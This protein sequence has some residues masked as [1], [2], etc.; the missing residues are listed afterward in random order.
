MRPGRDPR[1]ADDPASAGGQAPAG[2]RQRQ[3]KLGGQRGQ[4]PAR[5]RLA[6]A[7]L[8]V[9]P[10]TPDAAIAQSPASKCGARPALPPC[11]PEILLCVKCDKWLA[12]SSQA[13]MDCASRR[14]RAVRRTS[15]RCRT[16][17]SKGSIRGRDPVR[18]HRNCIRGGRPIAR[19]VRSIAPREPNHLTVASELAG[20]G[21]RSRN[22]LVASAMVVAGL[23]GAA[24][25]RLATDAPCY[26][27][28]QR[29]RA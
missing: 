25:G 19:G 6:I 23:I 28:V 18:A 21:P 3:V 10:A 2:R 24:R 29:H 15:S 16:L 8:G 4:R 5:R 11:Y 13:W 7:A 14:S 27:G 9:A 17:E 26:S 22:E 12:D 1:P 20:G